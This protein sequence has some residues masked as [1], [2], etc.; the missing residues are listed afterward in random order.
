MNTKE[1][2]IASARDL[3]TRYGYKKVSMDEIANSARVTKKTVYSYFKDKDSLFEYFIKEE[4]E[5]IKNKIEKNKNSS[6]DIIDFVSTSVKNIISHQKNSLLINNVFLESK[7]V[8]SKTKKFLELYEE[9]IINYIESLINE[10]IE[11][12]IIRKCNTHLSAFI[13]YK[14]YL[15]V[16]FEYKGD[17][18]PDQ[19]S[20]EIVD[21]LK[22]G[23]LNK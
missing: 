14:I 22:N 20:S 8:E 6:K 15:N 1:I 3:F 21:I 11:Q 13:I 7:D 4:I 12:K 19:A 10:A 2:I 16:M 23:I 5:Y 18:N 17:I 9:N